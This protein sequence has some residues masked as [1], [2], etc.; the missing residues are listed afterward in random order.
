MNNLIHKDSYGWIDIGSDV[1]WDEH[2]GNW[3]K[4]AQDGSWYVIT[5]DNLE[6]HGIYDLPKYLATVKNIEPREVDTEELK[7]ALQCI[8]MDFKD[9]DDELELVFALNSHGIFATLEEISGDKNPDSIKERAIKVA[10]EFMSD[11]NKLNEALDK[12]INKIGTTNRGARN[13]DILAGLKRYVSNG[14]IGT[15]PEKDMMVRIFGT[16]H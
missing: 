4:K 15:N 12:E 1:N 14:E 5:F 9:V 6:G 2:G 13:G 11:S 7:S 10:E 16:Y 8:G 3:A